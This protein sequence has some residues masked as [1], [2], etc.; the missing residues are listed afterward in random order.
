MKK[1]RILACVLLAVCCICLFCGCS[2]APLNEG[3]T[4][5]E[6]TWYYSDDLVNVG[7]NLFAD[8]GGFLFI[9]DNV[10]TIRYGI[11]GGQFYV[12]ANGEQ[13]NV[14]SFR[15]TEEGL[16]IGGMLFVPVKENPRAEESIQQALSRAEETGE[17]EKQAPN[18]GFYVT[19]A[20]AFAL[21]ILILVWLVR[22]LRAK[23]IR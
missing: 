7:Y 9:G 12:S 6:G 19:A 11:Y 3:E 18:V 17:V 5:L 14:L 13:P 15:E 1:I 4:Y 16:L 8:G 23:K 10:S 22:L 21:V 20:I 2:P